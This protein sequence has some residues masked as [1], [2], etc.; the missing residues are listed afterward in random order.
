MPGMVICLFHHPAQQARALNG[1]HI[2]T[3]FC[4]IAL[5]LSDVA[6]DLS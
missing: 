4:R 3:F 2:P 1:I 6:L 5:N